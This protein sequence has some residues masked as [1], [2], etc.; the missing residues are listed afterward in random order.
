MRLPYR[1]TGARKAASPGR[2]RISRKTIARGRPGCLGCTCQTRVHAFASFAH[3]N[4]GAPS[5]RLSLRPLF[6]EGQRNCGTRVKTSRGNESACL[7]ASLRGAKEMTLLR[8]LRK[9]RRVQVRRSA[10]AR[11]RKQSSY[12]RG[13]RWIASRSLSSGARSRDLFA[14]NDGRESPPF[15]TCNDRSCTGLPA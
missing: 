7:S 13:N 14:R 6:G 1:T 2:A 5:T 15:N 3:G 11:R 8:L 9:L 12:P 10:S 4:A